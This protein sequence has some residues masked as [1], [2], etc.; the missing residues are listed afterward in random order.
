MNS[1]DHTGHKRQS[2]TSFWTS[3]PGIALVIFLAVG[4]LFLIYEHRVHLL[5]GNALLIGLLALCV[6]VHFFMHS[7][8]GS[9]DEGDR[10]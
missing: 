7:H 2:E 4:V 5:T 8:G 3:R 9:R 10:E 1:H 6:G